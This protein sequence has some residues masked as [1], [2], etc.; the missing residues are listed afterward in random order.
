MEAETAVWEAPVSGSKPHNALCVCVCV[1][2]KVPWGHHEAQT[3]NVAFV[4][5]AE[6]LVHSFAV[7]VNLMDRTI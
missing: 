7:S 3:N 2:G 1:R 5:D 6:M 4:L